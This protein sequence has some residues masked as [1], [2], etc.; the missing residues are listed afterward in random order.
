GISPAAIGSSYTTWLW[1][2]AQSP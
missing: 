1:Q 2:L